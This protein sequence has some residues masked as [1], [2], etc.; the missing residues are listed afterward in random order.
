[1]A[2]SENKGISL[3]R[4]VEFARRPKEKSKT[5]NNTVKREEKIPRRTHDK[6]SNI[7]SLSGIDGVF[8]EGK[9]IINETIKKAK[10][11]AGDAGETVF[12]KNLKKAEELTKKNYENWRNA[13]NPEEKEKHLKEASGN[14]FNVLGIK[15]K[16]VY[17]G[18]YMAPYDVRKYY[19]KKRPRCENCKDIVLDLNKLPNEYKKIMNLSEVKVG[20]SIGLE[21]IGKD[22]EEDI[23]NM[24][25]KKSISI[26]GDKYKN[27]DE[28]INLENRG[29]FEWG[30]TNVKIKDIS[31]KVYKENGEYKVEMT[32][33][34]VISDSFEDAKD[35]FNVDYNIKQE[36][37]NGK[38]FN[39][40]MEGNPR[41][42]KFSVKNLKEISEKLAVSYSN[43]DI[44]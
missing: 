33:T 7:I 4:M 25:G 22:I 34:P 42:L 15:Y 32:Y 13:K 24:S 17:L 28:S 43:L 27:R 2:E 26:E 8:K 16:S 23:K 37:I 21:K 10:L 19:Q 12:K 6:T 38:A 5:V 20:F 35:I 30:G 31:G 3:E 14:I 1:M 18:L 9:K 40:E 41:K 36:L 39:M 44:P 11:A 29:S